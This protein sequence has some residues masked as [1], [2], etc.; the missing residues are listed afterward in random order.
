MFP[1]L[2]KRARIVSSTGSFFVSLDRVSGSG[3]VYKGR[4]V[5]GENVTTK[6]S[7]QE[8]N[9]LVDILFSGDYFWNSPCIISQHESQTS[10]GLINHKIFHIFRPFSHFCQK[11]F[12]I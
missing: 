8:N 2:E 9:G 6:D 11:S 10:L 7:I 3:W 5:M 1:W 12:E 4:V